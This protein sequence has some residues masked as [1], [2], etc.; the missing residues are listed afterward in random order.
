MSWLNSTWCLVSAYAIIVAL[1]LWLGRSEVAQRRTENTERLWPAFWFATALLLVAMA[2]G[3][4]SDAG[5]LIAD[6]GR[7]QARSEGWYET[8]RSLQAIV[9][10]S[11]AVI[12]G[13][14]VLV[15]IWRVPE[16]R[17]RYLPTALV[18]FSLVCYAG[19][20]LI[21]LHQV[22]ALLHNRSIGEVRIGT[23]VEL[24]LLALI[25]I[26]ELRRLNV[27]HLDVIG[28]PRTKVTHS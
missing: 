2:I 28:A 9:I 12:W 25:L 14:V 27:R 18:V 16:R 4:V 13:V 22:D 6:I 24:S 11:I 23:I 19:I 3:R 10:A 8:R 1:T 21:S 26:V 20:R 17:R 7:R 5:D 15:A